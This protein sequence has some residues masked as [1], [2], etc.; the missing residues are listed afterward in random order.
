MRLGRRAVGALSAGFERFSRA[1]RWGWEGGFLD[2]GPGEAF[3]EGFVVAL[4]GVISH[5]SDADEVVLL[6]WRV[7]GA[8]VRG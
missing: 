8:D 2:Y 7:M 4:Q 1:S 3:S 5:Y 6:V